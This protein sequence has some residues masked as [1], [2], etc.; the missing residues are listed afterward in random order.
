MFLSE[1]QAQADIPAK[2]GKGRGLNQPR[3]PN[4]GPSKSTGKGAVGRYDCKIKTAK[5]DAQ[6]NKLC[7]PFNDARGCSK[8]A[9]CPDRHA[10]DVLLPK[11]EACG[12]T[13]H[14]R[15]RHKGQTVPLD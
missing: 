4:P 9:Q 8:G 13:N 12:L 7:K 2:P 6:K 11:G 3:M 5:Y 1:P 15:V 10:C 14:N